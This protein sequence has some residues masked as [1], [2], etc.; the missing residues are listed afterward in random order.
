VQKE[1]R[2]EENNKKQKK[3]ERE[4]LAYGHGLFT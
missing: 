2:K 1:S 3:K 4:K